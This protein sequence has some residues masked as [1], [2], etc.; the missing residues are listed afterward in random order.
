MKRLILVI[1]IF[2]NGI[3][4][5][6]DE[7]PQVNKEMMEKI[8]AARIGLIT[9]RLELTPEQ[10]EKFWPIYREFAQERRSIQQNLRELRQEANTGNISEDQSKELVK[11]AYDLKQREL[12]LEK[13]YSDRLME[14]I[15]AR[16]LMSLRQAETDFRDELIRRIQQRNDSQLRRQEMRDRREEFLKE[17]RGN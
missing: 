17:K 2:W 6:Q 4:L 10:A 3:L 15:T 14:V 7:T 9:E 16:Q 11:K 5:A 13:T 12:S 8:E 1:F